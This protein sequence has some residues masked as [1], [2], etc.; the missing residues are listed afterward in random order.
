MTG[1]K[2]PQRPEIR[3]IKPA[4]TALEAAAIGAAIEQFERETAPLPN[5]EHNLNAWQ[6]AA[7]YEA[8]GQS[9]ASNLWGDSTLWGN[10]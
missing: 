1:K 5:T 10:R 8:S 6:R 2:R 7:I 9:P 3:A 4:A